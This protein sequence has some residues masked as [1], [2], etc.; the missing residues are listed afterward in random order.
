MESLREPF[1]IRS[2]DLRSTLGVAPATLH[3]ILKKVGIEPLPDEQKTFGRGAAKNILSNDVRRIFEMRG[4]RYPDK[5]R[6]IVFMICKGGVGKTTSSFYVANR[7]AAYGAR[8]LVID[9]DSQGNLTSAFN[10]EQYGVDID[11]GTP[12]LLD[13][14]TGQCTIQEAI[15]AIT[16]NLHLLPSN[17]LNANLE[18]KI[19]EGF[20]NPSL[21]IKKFITPLYNKYEYILIDCAP[22]LNLTNTAIASAADTVILPVSPDKFSQLGLDQTLRELQ[23]IEAD[24]QLKID[25][26]IIFTR[27]DGR[28]FT[29]LK[30]LA[31]IAEKHDDIR[32][33]TAIRTSADVKNAITKREDLFSYK[34]SNAK[35]DYDKFTQELM[36]IDKI[37]QKKSPAS[38]T[39]N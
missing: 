1:S 10:L 20:K 6:V 9:A 22:A 37:F 8:V 27:Y 38:T 11:E 24:F 34:K 17:P 15:I 12:V 36:G 32:F 14:V 16:P 35:E 26:K 19:R 7:L 28:E 30:Y 4:F 33:S 31:E 5:A 39:D 2:V 13:V 25:K 3:E 23:Q 29:S 21:P 18:G